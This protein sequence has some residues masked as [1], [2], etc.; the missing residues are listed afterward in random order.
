MAYKRT[1]NTSKGT[2]VKSTTTRNT[3]GKVTRSFSTKDGN[4]RRTTT[5]H[6]NGSVTLTTTSKGAS[7]YTTRKVLSPKKVKPKI[8]KSKSAKTTK[9]KITKFK[10]P[11]KPKLY[12]PRATPRTKN[13][14][15]R[16]STKSKPV[17]LTAVAWI[18]G[19]MFLAAILSH[20]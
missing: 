10:A 9:T 17:S 4:T 12:K 6:Q 20:I 7:G 13:V 14:N 16:R 18:L 15:R 19:F 1:S 11:L 8:V 3:N 5:Q 2:G